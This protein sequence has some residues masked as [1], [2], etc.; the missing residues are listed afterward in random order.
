ML[1]KDLEML[2]Q[3]EQEHPDCTQ[4]DLPNCELANVLSCGIIEDLI[5]KLQ[6]R[7]LAQQAASLF[8]DGKYDLVVYVFL[9]LSDISICTVEH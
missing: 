3:F 7:T 6:S 2:K 8:A 1:E 4:I 5:Q 9:F